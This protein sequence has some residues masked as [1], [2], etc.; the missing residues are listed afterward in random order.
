MTNVSTVH[1]HSSLFSNLNF[2]NYEKHKMY[3]NFHKNMK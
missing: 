1:I 3:F 2:K